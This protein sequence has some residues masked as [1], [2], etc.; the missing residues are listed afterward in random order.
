MHKVISTKSCLRT[1]SSASLCMWPAFRADLAY[2]ATRGWERRG[3]I[4][5]AKW[6][7]RA[8]ERV[9]GL[10]LRA[11]KCVPELVLTSLKC[12]TELVLTAHMWSKTGANRPDMWSKTGTNSAYMYGPGRAYL[13]GPGLVLS[14]LICAAQDWLVILTAKY[15]EHLLRCAAGLA[16]LPLSHAQAQA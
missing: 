8:L 10:V 11:L 15:N 9:P 16:A 1:K 6:V 2:G 3:L 7:L 4:C 14:L 5:A 12:G 13:S